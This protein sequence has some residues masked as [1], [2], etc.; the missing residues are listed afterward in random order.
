MN[1][2]V[3]ELVYRDP[4][5]AQFCGE[6]VGLGRCGRVIVG[7][8]QCGVRLNSTNGMG[9]VSLALTSSAENWQPLASRSVCTQLATFQDTFWFGVVLL[10]ANV[11]PGPGS[12]V[13]GLSQVEVDEYWLT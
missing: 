11:R 5:A 1:A 8:R 3:S 10:V 13:G 2:G 7:N 6:M 12:W 4:F 9:L